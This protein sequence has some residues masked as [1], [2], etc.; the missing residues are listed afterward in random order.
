MLYLPTHRSHTQHKHTDLP[1]ELPT[2]LPTD[3]P[4]ELPT[5]LLTELPIPSYVPIQNNL[6]RATYS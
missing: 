4:T 6:F 5:E 2:E 1:T 3:L